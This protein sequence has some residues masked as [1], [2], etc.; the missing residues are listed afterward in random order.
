MK[1]VAIMG[2]PHKGNSLKATQQIED[3]L[4]QFGDAGHLLAQRPNR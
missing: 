4:A 2:S 1:I 3:K